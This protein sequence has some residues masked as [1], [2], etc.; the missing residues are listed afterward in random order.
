MK[1]CYNKKRGDYMKKESNLIDTKEELIK[2][3]TEEQME[4][5]EYYKSKFSYTDEQLYPTVKEDKEM[6]RLEK[7]YQVL[8]VIFKVEVFASIFVLA[9]VS[10]FQII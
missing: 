2:N 6:M 4:I 8:Q 3:F 10:L 5:Y 1:L 9:F 7:T